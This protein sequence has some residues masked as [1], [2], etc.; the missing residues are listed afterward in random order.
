MPTANLPEK[1]EKRNK[2]CWLTEGD[3][4]LAF[5]TRIFL[6]GIGAGERENSPAQIKFPDL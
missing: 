2:M 5:D 3:E 4:V 6:V 1:G